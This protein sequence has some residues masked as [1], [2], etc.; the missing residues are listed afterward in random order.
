MFK[1]LFREKCEHDYKIIDTDYRTYPNYDTNRIE[2]MKYYILYCPKCDNEKRVN[3]EKYDLE[4]SKQ[5]IKR[6]Y[7]E[8]GY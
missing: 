3:S 6:R 5:S 2:M 4:K 7:E 1:W 8:R